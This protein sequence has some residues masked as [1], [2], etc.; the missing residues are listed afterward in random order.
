[1]CGSPSVC[2][3][4]YFYHWLS[5]SASVT[6]SVSHHQSLAQYLLLAWYLSLAQ[7]LTICHWL[8]ICCC[9]ISVAWL[10]AMHNGDFT[11]VLL[12]LSH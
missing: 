3:L 6:G 4:A 7:Y 8:S 5:I 11:N 10:N 2:G 12:A 9:L 1:M